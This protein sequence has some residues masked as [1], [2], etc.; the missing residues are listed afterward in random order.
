MQEETED[1]N[2]LDTSTHDLSINSSSISDRKKVSR[3]SPSQPETLTAVPTTSTFLDSVPSLD[4]DSTASIRII[5]KATKLDVLNAMPRSTPSHGD[6]N[7]RKSNDTVKQNRTTTTNKEKRSY[8]SNSHSDASNTHYRNNSSSN[9]NSNATSTHSTAQL[10]RLVISK[11]ISKKS[12][13]LDAI[14]STEPVVD[15]HRVNTHTN[16][17]TTLP[18]KVARTTSSSDQFSSSMKP[19]GLSGSSS[20][21]QRSAIPP[22]TSTAKNIP[23]SV[24]LRKDD[25][26]AFNH[27]STADAGYAPTTERNRTVSSKDAT[28]G[29]ALPHFTIN[30]KPEI[31]TSVDTRTYGGRSEDSDLSR[32]YR[33]ERDQ[34]KKILTD[35][36]PPLSDK[37]QSPRNSS[38]NPSHVSSSG[39]G[40][41]R[42]AV[43]PAWMDQDKRR[44]ED[45]PS[46]SRPKYSTSATGISSPKSRNS[47]QSSSS[48]IGRK[49]NAEL[50]HDKSKENYSAPSQT[51][52]SNDSNRNSYT[53]SSSSNDLKRKRDA[54]TE[55]EGPL[56]PSSEQSG[57][58]HTTTTADPRIALRDKRL[59][60]MDTAES[61]RSSSTTQHIVTQTKV[62][63]TVKVS[64]I[65]RQP[66]VLCCPFCKSEKLGCKCR[67]SRRVWLPLPQSR[68]RTNAT[69]GDNERWH[70]SPFLSTSN[71]QINVFD[72][73]I[74]SI[75]LIELDTPESGAIS[76]R[77]ASSSNNNSNSSSN[78]STVRKRSKY[79]E[80]IFQPM[81]KNEEELVGPEFDEARA[82]SNANIKITLEEKT[83]MMDTPKPKTKS[84]SWRDINFPDLSIAD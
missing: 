18:N 9:N 76:R 64:S 6:L 24:S 5:E 23:A 54:L 36:R 51:T 33:R 22:S 2:S 4:D 47:N 65:L 81:N 14:S 45:V 52:N 26:K 80:G 67:D 77:G 83:T 43:R 57:S 12:S 63:E 53:T 10:E 19:T 1:N 44:K 20:L 48:S 79:G 34:P 61:V 55:S 58:M 71:A 70:V 32:E 56:R 73:L 31:V 15:L 27:V 39:L 11:P 72:D 3:T 78:G 29:I 42:E 74:P 75:T 82:N 59:V 69:A 7:Q 62:D 68:W 13:V 41:G 37:V 60:P 16:N 28:H 66:R 17:N 38:A 8:Q 21:G 46:L 40:R 25:T 84:L 30:R 49:A 50:L 35:S